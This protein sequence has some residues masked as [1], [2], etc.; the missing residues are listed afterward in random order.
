MKKIY[1][2]V[3][4]IILNPVNVALA[5]FSGPYDVSNWTQI[6]NGGSIDTTGAPASIIEISSNDGAGPDNTD[7]TIAAV[8]SGT[9]T[10]NWSYTTTDVD[11]PSYDPFGWLL[12]GTFTQVT[13]DG[14]LINQSGTVTFPVVAGDVFGFRA[15]ATDSALGSASTTISNFSAPLL[16]PDAIPSL[17]SWGIILLSLLLII[18]ASNRSNKIRKI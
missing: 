2:I 15:H 3:L 8:D 12:N 16:A 18:T 14:G 4:L 13:N 6:L 9:V 17:S 5:D 1:L 7:F 10:F 11:G